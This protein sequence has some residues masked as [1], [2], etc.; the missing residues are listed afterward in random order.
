MGECTEQ[1]RQTGELRAELAAVRY[2][3]NCTPT[4]NCHVCA[5]DLPNPCSRHIAPHAGYFGCLVPDGAAVCQVAEQVDAGQLFRRMESAVQHGHGRAPLAPASCWPY[6]HSIFFE[7]TQVL[8]RDLTV[9]SAA[10]NVQ[11]NQ[12]RAAAC[13]VQQRA[14]SGV[15]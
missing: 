11:R 14:V 13:N 1:A 2:I 8:E 12:Q 6:I 5:S 10:R 15:Q 9:H 4:V 3:H 7:R